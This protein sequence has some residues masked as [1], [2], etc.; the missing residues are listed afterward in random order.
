MTAR[1]KRGNQGAN[2]AVVLVDLRNSLILG[3]KELQEYT[4]GILLNE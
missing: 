1:L 4:R 2:A 3:E